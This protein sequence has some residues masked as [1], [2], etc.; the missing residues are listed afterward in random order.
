MSLVTT[1]FCSSNGTFRCSSEA[2]TDI[3]G[4]QRPEEEHKVSLYADDMLLYTSHL[5][6]SLPKLVVLLKEFGQLSGCRVNIQ[7]KLMPVGTSNDKT[8]LN[9]LHF[10]I[11]PKKLKYL[12][13][14]ITEKHI[15]LTIIILLT[16]SPY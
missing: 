15:E 16:T 12:G 7:R 13:V 10:K 3:Q 4:I 2:K 5:L 6:A 9:L 11:S 1:P 8:S 14:R